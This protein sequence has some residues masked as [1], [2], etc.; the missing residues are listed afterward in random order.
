MY[1]LVLEGG[2]ARGS[3]QIG[4]AKALDELGIEISAI[5]GT[6]V[7]ALNGALLAQNKLDDAY[8]LWY[9]M[10]V[11]RIIDV[12]KATYNDLINF[13]LDANKM[14]DYYSYVM[15]LVTDGGLNIDPLKKL[16]EEYIDEEA[17]RKSQIDYGLVTIS[18]SDL[19]PVEVFLDEI[20]NGQLHNHLL[21]S[22]YL[23][24]FKREQLGGKSYI[25][26][27]LFDNAPINLI[28]KKDIT[29]II[30][31]RLNS[32][33]FRQSPKNKNLNIIEIEP[34]H[35]LGPML[36][37]DTEN[38]RKNLL[39]GYYDTLKV[40][41]YYDGFKYT[42]KNVPDDPYYLDILNTIDDDLILE[43]AAELGIFEGYPRRLLYEK[44]I[45]QVAGMLDASSDHKYREIF[46]ML[47]ENLMT[48]LDI[49]PYQVYDYRHTI[50]RLKGEFQDHK[51]SGEIIEK[52]P[53][54]LKKS[55]IVNKLL[56]D[57]FIIKLSRIFKIIG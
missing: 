31:V 38:S 40:F 15:S 20:P 25:D 36:D 32:V 42:F 14:N 11:G 1:G 53:G 50:E 45:P 39:M 35:D 3:Y 44:I 47:V 27:G 4:V 21:A 23:P 13:R 52:L 54:L 18:L 33:G 46:I 22:A 57:D 26:G 6:S 51:T 17:L 16:I 34:S 43:T 28:A 2:G 41:S 56:K 19:K 37:F 29:D 49:D 30:V 7:G 55:S 5:T 24:G 10:N 8:K 12:D 9:D 48:Q